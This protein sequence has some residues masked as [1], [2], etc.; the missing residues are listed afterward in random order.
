MV[1][2]SRCHELR[3]PA[4]PETE[5]G[6]ERAAEGGLRF[7][8]IPLVVIVQSEAQVLNAHAADCVGCPFEARLHRLVLA[9]DQGTAAHDGVRLPY[10]ED[11]P[12]A[13][14]VVLAAEAEPAVVFWVSKG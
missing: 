12:D 11:T 2:E 13:G 6:F 9:F 8:A 14:S 5:A 4:L 1:L 10:P 7:V 3:G